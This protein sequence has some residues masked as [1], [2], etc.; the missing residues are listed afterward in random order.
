LKQRLKQLITYQHYL[1]EIFG[2]R[3]EVYELV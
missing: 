1:S 3:H 2:L